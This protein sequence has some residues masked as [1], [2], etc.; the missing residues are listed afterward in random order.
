MKRASECQT[1]RRFASSCFG[2]A[3]LWPAVLRYT[4][5]VRTTTRGGQDSSVIVP[6]RINQSAIPPHSPAQC[7]NPEPRMNTNEPI[8]VVF[9]FFV[10]EHRE[11]YHACDKWSLCPDVS[12]FSLGCLDVSGNF[13]R[14]RTA[15][16][17]IGD[18][19]PS[20]TSSFAKRNTRL[21]HT[22]VGKP[23]SLLYRRLE[24]IKN[25]FC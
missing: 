9:F 17:A 24:Y 7:V 21:S 25:K 8:Q 16:P 19:T 6:S 10:A 3:A 2:P 11:S 15:A 5:L 13:M 12:P 20:M 18:H 22:D 14:L 1:T 4:T 23:V